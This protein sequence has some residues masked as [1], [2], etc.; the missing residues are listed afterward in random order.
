MCLRDKGYGSPCIYAMA[1]LAMLKTERYGQAV[2]E[3]A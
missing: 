3:R 1:P 2:K